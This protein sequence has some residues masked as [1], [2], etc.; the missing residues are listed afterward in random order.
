MAE[1]CPEARTH[2][3]RAMSLAVLCLLV[4]LPGC[5]LFANGES[6]GVGEAGGY[7]VPLFDGGELTFGQLC[8]VGLCTAE[9]V[10]LPSGNVLEIAVDLVM[11]ATLG[12]LA[13]E[14]VWT[15]E[16]TGLF[17]AG[18]ESV[19]D[20]TITDG[21]LVG[22]VPAEPV[23]R[24]ERG[25]DVNLVDGTRLTFD[26]AGSVVAVCAPESLC[27]EAERSEDRIVFEPVSFTSERVVFELEDGLVAAA[28]AADGRR[29]TYVYDKSQLVSV[30][31]STGSVRYDYTDGGALAAID[32]PTDHRTFRYDD[33]ELIGFTDRRG[34]EWAF[35]RA[36]DGS[37]LVSRPDGS[38]RTYRFEG[39][40]LI[41]ATDDQAGLVLRRV[42][43]DGQLVSEERPLD[44]VSSVALDDG[45]VRV[46]ETGQDGAVRTMSY[47]TD[48]YGRV[49]SM[50]STDGVV[51]YAYEGLGVG[52]ATVENAF[53]TFRYEY[54][55]FGLLAATEDA[56]GYRV[57]IS[58]DPNGLPV[59][60]SD[61]VTET[62]FEY[63]AVG[64]LLTETSADR[65]ATAEY[66]EV[67][68]VRGV[69][70]AAGTRTEYEYDD[71][72]RLVSASGPASDEFEYDGS[73]LLA[74]SS[75]TVPGV[76]LFDAPGPP[77]RR[78]AIRNDDGT[79][80]YVDVFGGSV[81]TDEWGRILMV[82]AGDRRT[83][84]AYDDAG[85]LVMLREAGEQFDLTYT[86]AGRLSSV[87]LDDVVIDVEWHGDLVTAITTSE[88]SDYRYDYDPSGRLVSASHGLLEWTYEYDD[89]GRVASVSSPAGTTGYTWDDVGRPAETRLGSGDRYEYVWDGD[90]LESIVAPD[91][92]VTSLA[93]ADGAVVAVADD[94]GELE[95]EYDSAGRIAGYRTPDGT[96]VTVG[97]GS[98]GVSSITVGDRTEEWAYRDGQV[99][100]VRIGEARFSLEWAAPG[101]LE[102]VLDDEGTVLIDVRIDDRGRVTTV[103]DEDGERLARFTWD[104][105]GVEEAV[106]DEQSLRIERDGEGRVESFRTEDGFEVDVARSG[107]VLERV[108]VG[109]DLVDFEYA[110]GRLRTS[111]A[112]WS[113]ERATIRWDDAGERPE[114]FTT[115]QGDGAFTFGADGQ[116]TSIAYDDRVRDV[117]YDDG[118]ARADG[119]GGEFL[120]DLFS[121]DG[122]FLGLAVPVESE[123]RSPLL[124]ALPP[125]L[126]LEMPSVVT[127]HAVATAALELSVPALPLPLVP[128]DPGV[129]AEAVVDQVFAI[130]A[131]VEI[132]VGPAHQVKLELRPSDNDFAGVFESSPTLRVTDSV[133][134]RLADDPCLLCRVVS[135]GWSVVQGVG[136]AVVSLVGFLWSNPITRA[137]ASVG[138]MATA[139]VSSLACQ[140]QLWCGAALAAGWVLL[141]ELLSGDSAGIVDAVV[142]AFV[143]PV[144]SVVNAVQSLDVLS[145]ATG[146]TVVASMLLTRRIFDGAPVTSRVLQGACS[147]RHIICISASR[148]PGAASNILAG[149]QAGAGRFGIVNRAGVADRRRA[150]LA[151]VPTRAGFDRD[152]FPMA[153][154]RL[155]NRNVRIAHIPSADNRG[156]GSFIGHQLAPI[157]NRRPITLLVTP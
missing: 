117:S 2:P 124:G 134:S 73:G 9:T 72:G 139:F 123:P 152:E 77:S 87:E 35:E 67:G 79:L 20:I 21:R 156:A 94:D 50:E 56:D 38:R 133:T 106:I 128:E 71:R 76:E 88:G 100:E 118:V 30:E 11:P 51:T 138:F 135:G 63:D 115:T 102:R 3:A 148:Y 13:V 142:S 82:D 153:V 37:V 101:V 53:G 137:V 48:A 7:S 44:G 29:T 39:E 151:G 58:R 114:S 80:T 149:Q 93:W 95:L 99:S 125:E 65:T 25:T 64:R 112:E 132:P 1:S 86:A 122:A 47:R 155:T 16:R 52:P 81:T 107:G 75:R 46:S 98:D 18:W 74:A 42:Y 141:A 121:D 59:R 10:A 24:P 23:A 68:A 17:G 54:D 31:A 91:G 116:V 119:T 109:D 157:S 150:A 43:S 6:G 26:A 130:G 144:R 57:E 90:H 55:E 40:R 83:E 85:R 45:S 84:R 69:V 78:D 28:V 66:D 8:D 113:G 14:R 111:S 146:T 12:A 110:D 104:R 70:D 4:A 49:V 33:G 61:G 147:R 41:E 105:F 108:A 34:G 127:A 19:W 126:G 145:I 32:G 62:E 103:D 143:E 136:G 15:G 27:V 129:L 120:D 22:L 92:E 97:Q 5:S 36:V 140:G 131:T 60:L 96:R 89:A 154:M